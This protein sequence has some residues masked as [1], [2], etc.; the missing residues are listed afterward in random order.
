MKKTVLIIQTGGLGDLFVCAPIAKWYADKGYLVY[1]PV[2]DIYFDMMCKYFPYACNLKID[3][4]YISSHYT[5]KL[6]GDWLR[7]DAQYLNDLAKT[8]HYDLVLDLA[9]RGSQPRERAGETFEQAKYR[10]GKVPYDQKHKLVW[11]R[12]ANAELKHYED[13]VKGNKKYVLSHLV[14]SR[15]D[16]AVMPGTPYLVVEAV[17]V[18]G[19]YIPDLY[20][21]A[22]QARE[23]YCVESAVHQ[24]L[25]GIVHELLDR[26]IKL[27]LL[28]RPTLQS[29]QSYTY[30]EHWDKS[31]M[32]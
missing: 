19:F 10:L 7:D 16:R 22:L 30:S 5:R 15:N 18:D 4:D 27:F 26:N 25:D 23:I 32:K 11:Q 17:R 20:F 8:W 21:T 14:S 6:T 28:S 29:G 24:F 2:R 9:D 1:W 13:L 12:D 31:L 3:Q